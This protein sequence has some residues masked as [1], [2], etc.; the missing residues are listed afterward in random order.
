MELFLIQQ[1]LDSAQVQL[2][3]SFIHNIEQLSERKDWVKDVNEMN[4]QM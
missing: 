4:S 2:F 3:Y 1:T